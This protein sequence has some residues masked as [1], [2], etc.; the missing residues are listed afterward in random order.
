[1]QMQTG[2]TQTHGVV[3]I[4]TMLRDKTSV[5]RSKDDIDSKKGLCCARAIVTGIAIIEN[6]PRLKQINIDR[7]MYDGNERKTIESIQLH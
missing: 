5:I 1:M 6:H 4:H 7:T 3:K 2:E